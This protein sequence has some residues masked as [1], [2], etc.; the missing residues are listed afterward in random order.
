MN[1]PSEMFKHISSQKTF[2]QV[3]WVLLFSIE[4]EWTSPDVLDNHR[5][6][7]IAHYQQ[8][9]KSFQ[10][11]WSQLVS[12]HKIGIDWYTAYQQNENKKIKAD[13]IHVLMKLNELAGT[14]FAIKGSKADSNIRLVCARL[15]E[16]YTKHDLFALIQFKVSEWRGTKMEKYIRPATLFQK[17]KIN[18]YINEIIKSKENNAGRTKESTSRYNQLASSVEAAKRLNG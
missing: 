13:A 1:I 7:I 18:G 5:D 6:R 10:P 16:G 17:S 12:D 8:L 15:N 11:D 2:V 9:N 4:D 3:L 14:C